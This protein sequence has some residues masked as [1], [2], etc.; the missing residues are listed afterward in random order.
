MGERKRKLAGL[1]A[2][3]EAMIRAGETGGDL[4]LET[5]DVIFM[6][7]RAAKVPPEMIAEMK[8]WVEKPENL[9]AL[10][11]FLQRRDLTGFSP[12]EIP[13]WQRRR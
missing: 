13:P 3:V 9:E 1:K 6:G 7:L 11:R 10:A 8:T 5:D 2:F 12:N 4:G